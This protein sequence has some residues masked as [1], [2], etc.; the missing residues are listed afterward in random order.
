VTIVC[1]TSEAP[2][3]EEGWL[4]TSAALNLPRAPKRHLVTRI[5]S[6]WGLMLLDG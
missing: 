4:S 6:F 3:I 5:S 1:S 2:R